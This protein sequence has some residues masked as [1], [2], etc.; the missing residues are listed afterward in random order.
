VVTAENGAIGNAFAVVN[1]LLKLPKQSL[2]EWVGQGT[3]LARLVHDDNS[4]YLDAAGAEIAD[5]VNVTFSAPVDCSS[6]GGSSTGG[7]STGGSS[8]GGSSTGGS[9]GAGGASN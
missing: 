8:T 1:P 4:P 2:A 9:G 7:S 6:M 5:T 3:L